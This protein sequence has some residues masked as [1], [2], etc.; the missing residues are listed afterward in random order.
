MKLK[1]IVVVALLV[2][3]LLP[4]M[5]TS[6]AEITAVLKSNIKPTNCVQ[7]QD[8]AIEKNGGIPVFYVENMA[9][10]I[11]ALPELSEKQI[12]HNIAVHCKAK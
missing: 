9:E 10:I 7:F 5:A 3:T 2:Q 1:P 4:A 6:T 11:K 12:I 8:A